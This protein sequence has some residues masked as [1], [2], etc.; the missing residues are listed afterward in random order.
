[1]AWMNTVDDCIEN[2]EAYLSVIHLKIY[3]KISLE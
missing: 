2:N 1:M 3:L